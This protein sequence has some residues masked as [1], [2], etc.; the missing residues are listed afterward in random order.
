MAFAEQK[1]VEMLISKTNQMFFCLF[2][3][4]TETQKNKAAKLLFSVTNMRDTERVVRG[5]EKRGGHVFSQVEG[6]QL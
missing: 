3:F 1:K 5:V 6:S 4:N 2:F